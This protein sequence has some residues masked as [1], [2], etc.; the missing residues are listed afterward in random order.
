MQAVILAGGLGTRLGQLTQII[1]KPM[2]QVC[3]KPFLEH[4]L[5]HLRQSGI[6]D[7]VLCIGHFGEVIE[8]YFKDGKRLGIGIRY[9]HDGEKLLGP[10]GA[11]KHAEPLLEET[12]FV[13][14][15][16]AYLRADY[17]RLMRTLLD[18][19]KLGVM[20]VYENHDLYGK[21]DIAV[22]DGYVVR[23]DKAGRSKDLSWVNYGVTA[24]KK[25]ALSFIPPAKQCGEE[26]FYREMI[27]RKEL[28]AFQVGER[29]YEIGSPP[30]LKE[31]EQFI[32]REQ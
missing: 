17:T 10:A 22:K 26:E 24:L 29:F 31:F 6:S 15:G 2:V 19:R 30:A 4:E 18:S 28:L 20:A 5:V 14:Y 12:F 1:P 32:S 25:H 7:F 13:T 8:D 23:Y 9:S 27:L 16:D 3:G 11:L 21:S